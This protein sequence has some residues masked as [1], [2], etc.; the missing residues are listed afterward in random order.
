[1]KL[2]H[3]TTGWISKASLLTSKYRS[4]IH[5]F[6]KE[7][8]TSDAALPASYSLGT[9]LFPG[10]YNDQYVKLTAHPI[11]CGVKIKQSY[12]SNPPHLQG[13]HSNKFHIP[14]YN[15]AHNT[16]WYILLYSITTI[17][18]CDMVKKNSKQW[19]K[20]LSHIL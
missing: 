20:M 2:R 18:K 12:F 3:W 4:E 11:W 6:F 7:S 5:S 14:E 9:V 16:I 8:R 15:L 10:E 17:M 1:M 13:V 19:E